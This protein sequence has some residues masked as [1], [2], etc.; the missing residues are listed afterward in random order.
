MDKSYCGKS[1]GDCMYKEKLNCPGCKAGPGRFQSDECA[2]G[3]CARTKAIHCTDCSSVGKCS[4][5]WGRSRVP[6]QLEGAMQAAQR[7]RQETD[8][9]RAQCLPVM[10][11][12]L[13]LLFRAELVYIAALI[14]G[15]SALDKL[16]PFLYWPVVLAA[17][18]AMLASGV[19]LIKMA[20]VSEKEFRLAGLLTIVVGAMNLVA[21]AIPRGNWRVLPLLLAA[22]L[23]L[24][25]EFGSMYFYCKGNEAAMEPVDPDIA[26]DWHK[27]WRWYLAVWVLRVISVAAMFWMWGVYAFI[28]II[29]VI[30]SIGIQVLKAVYLYKSEKACWQFMTYG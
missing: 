20:P 3:V 18:G 7:E 16:L 4:K 30:L 12:W 29:G 23:Q 1:C 9:Y 25:L 27:L 28:D 2:I 10:I 5:Y 8:E 6:L 24:A 19:F 22:I 11:K 14:V 26:W 17:Y 15:R 13:P 21:L